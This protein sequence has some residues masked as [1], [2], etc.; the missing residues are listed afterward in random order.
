MVEKLYELSHYYLKNYNKEYKRYFLKKHPLKSRFYIVIG[1]RGIGKTTA[2]IQHMLDA[3]NQN[4]HTREM[5]Y[6]PV[7]HILVARYSLYEIAEIFYKEE[8]VKLI[9]FDEIHKYSEWARDLNGRTFLTDVICAFSKVFHFELF[10]AAQ[11][12]E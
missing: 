3:F 11:I 5:L 7:D 12:R 1:Q 4:T 9:F 8:G 10:P 6:V 2:L